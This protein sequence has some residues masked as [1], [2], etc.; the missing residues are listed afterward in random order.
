MTAGVDPAPGYD[1]FATRCPSRQTL[2]TVTGRWGALTLAALAD[3]PMRF[4]VLRRRVDG[5]SEKMLSQTLKL[6]EADG[7]V[8]RT[9]HGSVPPRVDYALTSAGSVVAVAV[10][11]LVDAVYAVQPAVQQAR[12]AT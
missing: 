1:V 12:D 2:E 6:L 9:D 10:M 7:L 4:G 8:T 5:V 11:R 3:G